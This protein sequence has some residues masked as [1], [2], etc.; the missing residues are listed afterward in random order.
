[1]KEGAEEG[2]MDV[3]AVSGGSGEGAGVRSG[4]G[5]KS[6]GLSLGLASDSFYLQEVCA[7]YM[8]TS[9]GE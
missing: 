6:L 9:D 8:A 2:P 3:V 4:H 1:M 5:S 7:Q